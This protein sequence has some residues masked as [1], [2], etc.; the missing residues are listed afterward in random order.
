MG[1]INPTE[2]KQIMPW[3]ANENGIFGP[4][5]MQTT[6]MNLTDDKTVR[7]IRFVEQ[8]IDPMSHILDVPTGFGRHAIELAKLGHYVIGVDI[9]QQFLDIAAKSALEA[10]VNVRW[11]KEDMRHIP[12]H[13]KNSIFLDAVINLFTAFGY[14][15]DDRQDQL[16]LNSMTDNLKKGGVFIMDFFNFYRLIRDYQPK[17]YHELADGST[18][19]KERHFDFITGCNRE[20]VTKINVDGSKEL[21]ESSIRCYTLPELTKMFKIAG[22][23]IDKVFGDFEFAPLTLDSMRMIIVAYKD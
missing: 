2:E 10:K 14:L 6:A 19:L 21:Y 9:S 16:A 12:W 22:M 20:K 13:F 18:Q 5:Y 3:Y 8:F 15:E 7:E 1:T 4:D 11:I 23:T 17:S